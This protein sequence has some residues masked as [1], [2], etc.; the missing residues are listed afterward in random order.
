[1]VASRRRAKHRPR[2]DRHLRTKRTVASGRNDHVLLT[3]YLME[4]SALLWPPAGKRP[5]TV[6]AFAHVISAQVV[7]GGRGN[8][9][10]VT[11]G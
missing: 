11:G 6:F 7:V 9:Q 8:E 1:M 5:A 10:H 2:Y 4:S 3:V